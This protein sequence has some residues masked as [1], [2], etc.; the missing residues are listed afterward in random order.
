LD[1]YT[2]HGIE[3]VLDRT[4]ILAALRDRGFPTPAV[5]VV[6]GS[7][8][9]PTVRV[10]GDADHTQLVLEFRVV[11]NQTIIPGQDVL[12]VEWLL[13]QNPTAEFDDRRPR[14]PGQ[15]HPGL[16]LL[17]PVAGLLMAMAEALKL[18][19]VVFMPA[20]YY[21]AVLS[22]HHLR[23]ADPEAQGRFESL[24]QALGHLSLSEASRALEQGR[25]HD[26]KT[27]LPVRWEPSPMVTPQGEAMRRR[28]NSPEYRAA[29]EAA[30]GRHHF[31]VVDSIP[32]EY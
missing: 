17:G 27:D 11:R 30:R 13:L 15:E 10:F 20:N 31:T 7:G 12:S 29:V 25:V 28:L 1:H 21:I 18:S 24:Y 6:G 5:E 16:G 32:G 4:G 8:V 19:A 14:L 26:S 9:P 22:Q 23:F 3:L 2:P